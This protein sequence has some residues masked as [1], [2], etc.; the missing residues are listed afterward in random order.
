MNHCQSTNMNWTQSYE[1]WKTTKNNIL[2]KKK[3]LH[4]SD[5]KI[6][7]IIKNH[8]DESL[9]SH[10]N[11]FKTLQLLRQTCQFLNMRQHVETYIKK[12]FNCQKNKHN[13]HVKYD[14]IQYQ[15]SSKSSWNEIAMNFIIKLS[16]SKNSATIIE[17]DSILMIMNKFIKYSHIIFFKKKFIAKQLETII[18]NRLIRYHEISRN[19]IND[20]DK[21]FTFN[22]W[23]T[24]IFLL[25]TRLRMSI[26]Y[27]SQANDQTKRTNQN[28]EQYLRHYIN[29]VQ[30][31]WVFFLSMTQLTFNFKQSK[32]TKITSFFANFDKNFNLFELFKKNKS[33]QSIIEKIN[34]LKKIHQNITAMQDTSIKYQKKNDISAKKN[35]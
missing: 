33:A 34:T 18:L 25:N 5:D 17:Y 11:V 7:E 28:L 15:K 35:K 6:D 20:R 14:E 21:L 8:H 22:Y 26:V 2:L 10:S 32:T 23:K 4:I 31:N 3:R 16:K 27:H 1:Y 30:N 19:I 9:Q 29:N 13:I 24:L 12:C